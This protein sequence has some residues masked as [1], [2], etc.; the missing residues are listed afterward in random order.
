MYRSGC[1]G[2][3]S[4][5]YS[6]FLRELI[7]SGGWEAEARLYEVQRGVG[8]PFAWVCLLFEQTLLRH[9]C[10]VPDNYRVFAYNARAWTLPESL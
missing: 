8:V 9:A 2:S 10:G 5:L 3:H 7:G 4:G 1:E 6:D